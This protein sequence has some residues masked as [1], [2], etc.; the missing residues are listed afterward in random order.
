MENKYKRIL[1]VLLS[2]VLGLS[3]CLVSADDLSNDL[4]V[5][6]SVNQDNQVCVSH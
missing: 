4:N 6:A 3:P 2:F 5:V 1:A